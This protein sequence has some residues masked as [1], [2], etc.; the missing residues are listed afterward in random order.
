MGKLDG[1]V[2]LI[3]GEV[4]GTTVT[5]YAGVSKHEALAD[6]ETLTIPVVPIEGTFWIIHITQ[7][8]TADDHNGTADDAWTA[9]IWVGGS[10]H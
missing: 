2:A 7:S 4:G 6:G 10:E 5:N 3:T 8:K 1:K 9:P